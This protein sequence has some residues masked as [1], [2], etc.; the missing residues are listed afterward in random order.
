VIFAQCTGKK[1]DNFFLKRKAGNF[2]VPVGTG[3]FW[4][5]SVIFCKKKMLLDQ[6]SCLCSA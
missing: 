6:L 1:Y 2:C 5:R 3:M 4:S